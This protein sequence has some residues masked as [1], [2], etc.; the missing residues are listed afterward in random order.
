[1]DRKS[2][3][4]NLI[5]AVTAVTIAPKL[6]PLAIMPTQEFI[7]FGGTWMSLAEYNLWKE[8]YRKVE[9]AYWYGSPKR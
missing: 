1:M 3:I 8:W 7:Q 2:F 9:M 4:K 6:E 5:C